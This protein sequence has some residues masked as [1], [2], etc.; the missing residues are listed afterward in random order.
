MYHGQNFIKQL[1]DA[2][3]PNRFDTLKN[4]LNYLKHEESRR[5]TGP[6]AFVKDNIA[7]FLDA[8]DT[9]RG[10]CS[11]IGEDLYR[12]TENMDQGVKRLFSYNKILFFKSV[13]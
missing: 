5:A 6:L 11:F 10:Q 4:G 3:F 1:C 8:L 2:F 9:L 13:L 12:D 7:T